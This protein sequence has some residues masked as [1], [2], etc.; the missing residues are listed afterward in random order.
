MIGEDTDECVSEMSSFLR[1]IEEYIVGQESYLT[2][3]ELLSIVP[4]DK[5][6]NYLYHII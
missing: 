2:M 5:L 4:K 6:N 1:Q 3:V